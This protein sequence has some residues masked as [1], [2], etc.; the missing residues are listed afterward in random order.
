MIDHSEQFD[1]LVGEILE[2]VGNGHSVRLGDFAI[3]PRG[4]GVWVEQNGEAVGG[5]SNSEYGRTMVI[6]EAI[7]AALKKRSQNAGVEVEG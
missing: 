2:C 4:K 5:W 3:V 1:S 7:W 6:A